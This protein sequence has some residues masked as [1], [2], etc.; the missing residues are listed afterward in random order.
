MGMLLIS[1]FHLLYSLTSSKDTAGQER[2]SSLSTAFFRGADA[3]ILMFDVND[4]A[5]MLA[6][7][8]WWANFCDKAPVPDQDIAEYCSVLV[9]NKIDMVAEDGSWSVSE[10]DALEF[11]DELMSPQEEEEGS[12]KVIPPELF[13]S[14]GNQVEQLRPVAEA[15]LSDPTP[16]PIHQ[17]NSKIIH[18]REP[19]YSPKH[20]LSKSYSRSRPSSRF[21]AG[22]M[23]STHTALTIY[24]TPSS[25]LL[26]TRSSI[27]QSARSSPEP[28]SQSE[29]D[30]SQSPQNRR[31]TMTMLSRESTGSDSAATITPSRFAREREQHR[32]SNENS[33]RL[34]SSQ[35][36]PELHYFQSKHQTPLPPE[37][38]PHLF[39]TSAKTGEGVDELFE[40]I[41]RRVVRKWEYDEWLDA[42][43]MH[44]RD[45]TMSE[46]DT[47]MGS[48]RS[49]SVRL[50]RSG[51]R[52]GCC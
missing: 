34:P 51:N 47:L 44:F 42:R 15:S 11:L 39:F 9:G 41:A 14:A 32:V 5:S 24:H 8:K 40:Y 12:V 4:H 26:D 6:T 16:I 52:G 38:G 45:T 46:E 20:H 30:L 23:S 18:A 1:S 29:P 2:F 10:S 33:S 31:R 28:W 19:S 21:Y 13:A 37:R 50:D 25:S 3:A 49:E 43:R 48:R 35:S 27:Y 17:P 22:T 36:S 7:K